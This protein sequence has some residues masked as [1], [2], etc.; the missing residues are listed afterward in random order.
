MERL[1]QLISRAYRIVPALRS[2]R[3]V[4][5]ALLRAKST[6]ILKHVPDYASLDIIDI[7]HWGKLNDP[8]TGSRVKETVIE[9]GTNQLYIFKET[10]E[11]R[12]A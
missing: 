1:A 6:R 11:F 3:S 2:Y 9:P 10:K 7:T 4:R 12:E 8:L 5:A